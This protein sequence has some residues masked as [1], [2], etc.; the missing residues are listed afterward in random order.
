MN[1]RRA[2]ATVTSNA[3]TTSTAVTT[4]ETTFF[5]QRSHKMR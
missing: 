3:Q 2:R 4:F 1:S 5:T